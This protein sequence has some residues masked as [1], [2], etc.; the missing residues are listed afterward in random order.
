MDIVTFVQANSALLGAVFAAVF[1]ID[2]FANVMTFN[3]RFSSAIVTAIV[4]IAFVAGVLFALGDDIEWQPLALAGALMF[5]V[6]Y[7]GNLLS[8]SSKVV[9]AFVTAVIFMVPFIVGM[10]Y[11]TSGSLPY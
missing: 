7:L 9:N 2:Y 1:V 11:L 3:S 4:L 10:M 6:A 8:F 5:A